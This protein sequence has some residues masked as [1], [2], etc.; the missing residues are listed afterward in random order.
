[1]NR[2]D[3]CT[4]DHCHVCGSMEDLRWDATEEQLEALRFQLAENR[5]RLVCND[6]L[7]EAL[8]VG[9]ESQ[10]RLMAIDE[11]LQCTGLTALQRAQYIAE[12]KKIWEIINTNVDTKSTEYSRDD[13]EGR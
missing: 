5:I 8:H 9:M 6:C 1:M 7:E 3:E 2:I 11:I 4:K 13:N 10:A 12:R